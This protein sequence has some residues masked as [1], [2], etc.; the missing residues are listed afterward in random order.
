VLSRSAMRRILALVLPLLACSGSPAETVPDGRVAQVASSWGTPP[1]RLV[2][3]IAV[4]D[5]P[6][7]EAASIRAQTIFA[8]RP[9][10]ERTFR[11]GLGYDGALLDPAAWH[12][13]DLRVVIVHPSAT[14]SARVFGPSDDPRLAL[15]AADASIAQV[16]A[17]AD[18]TAKAIQAF[19]ASEGDPYALLDASAWTMRLLAH[20]RAP[21]DAHETN[22]VA[23]LGDPARKNLGIFRVRKV[24]LQARAFEPATGRADSW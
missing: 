7:P 17:M 23:A 15:V 9:T 14:G 21:A 20:A 10:L 8:L 1:A 6:S 4:D 24:E 16:D 5:E 3:V 18:A 19:V 13:V 2:I 11:A 22:L 12:P